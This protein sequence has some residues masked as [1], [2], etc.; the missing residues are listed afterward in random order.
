MYGWD[1]QGKYGLKQGDIALGGVG[2][3]LS[4]ARARLNV[5][6]LPAVWLRV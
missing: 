5:E 1:Y 3:E 2:F 6:S 4:R